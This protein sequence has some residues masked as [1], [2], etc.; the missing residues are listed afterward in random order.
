[1]A[2]RQAKTSNPLTSLAIYSTKKLINPMTYTP[3]NLK[4]QIVRGAHLTKAVG[5]LVKGG[6]RA[7]Y[8]NHNPQMTNA[9]II[10]QI[11]GF[12]QDICHSVNLDVV[13]LKPMPQEHALWT[14][15]H[16]SWLDIPV[17]GSVVPTFF[18]SKAEIKKW[19]VVGWLARTA[20][21]LFIQRG[22]GD[23]NEVSNQMAQFLKDG[24]P[25]VF[26]P[27]ATTTDG[28]AIKKLH[29]KL[30][31]S[32]IDTGINIQPIVICYVNKNGQLDDKIPFCGDIHFLQSVK[33]VLD[34]PKATAYVLPLEPI[35]PAGKS[36][37]EI[38]QT[39]QQR[40]IAGLNELHQ[41]VVWQKVN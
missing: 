38:T 16:I 7:Y 19:P 35:N 33:N 29:G 20:N 9:K 12:C 34:N 31:Q 37:D 11:Q 14:S 5:A 28:K 40:M 17:I 41:Q 1:M 39:L 6:E 30:L 3:K 36:R 15:N 10:E 4:R 21:T 24:S 23:T 27:E 25:V 32:A 26:F 2:K 22:S 13:C 18:L 8:I